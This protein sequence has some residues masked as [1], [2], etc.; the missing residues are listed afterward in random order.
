[1]PDRIED[2][3]PR[4]HRARTACQGTSDSIADKASESDEE[5]LDD[6]ESSTEWN[7]SH[8]CHSKFI[9]VFII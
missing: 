7:L 1:M 3:K 5:C 8:F 4:F 2:M 6:N 9:N